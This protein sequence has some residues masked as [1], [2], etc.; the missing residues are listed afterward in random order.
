MWAG[1]KGFYLKL[2]H[3]QVGYKR[4]NEG[5][6]CN[7]CLTICMDLCTGTDVKSALTSKEVMTSPDSSL[8]PCN[9]WMK[10]C[11]FFRSWGDWPTRGLMM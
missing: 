3:E 6:C 10:C 11:V 9:C 8:L 4:T 2:F 1:A 7:F 5:S